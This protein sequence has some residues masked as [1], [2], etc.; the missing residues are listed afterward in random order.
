M[1]RKTNQDFIQYDQVEKRQTYQLAE[2]D[3]VEEFDD[4]FVV[5]T[6]DM[7]APDFA[8][9]LGEALH[10]IGFAILDGH[11]VNAALYD[12][13]S[14]KVEEMFECLTLAEKMRFRA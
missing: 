1:D 9:Q 5:R 4:D 3:G 7:R 10:D 2:S 13:A 14:R 12:E 6:C 8:Q 11:G